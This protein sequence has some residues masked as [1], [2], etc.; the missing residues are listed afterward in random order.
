MSTVLNG[1]KKILFL[2]ILHLTIKVENDMEGYQ[3][4]KRAAETVF[5]T[6]SNFE[7]VAV[8]YQLLLEETISRKD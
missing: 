3:E 1:E 8:R 4:A 5:F 7:V 6:Q 2:K